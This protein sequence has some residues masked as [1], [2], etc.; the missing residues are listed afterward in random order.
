M[1]QVE[2]NIKSKIDPAFIEHVDFSAEADYLGME[3][4][5]FALKALVRR[6]RV[7]LCFSSSSSPSLLACS[8]SSAPSTCRRCL[9]ERGA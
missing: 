2:E 5:G 3:V 9:C 1:S 7:F 6:A 4:F 8:P